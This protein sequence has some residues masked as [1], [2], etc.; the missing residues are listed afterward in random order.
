MRLWSVAIE[1]SVGDDGDG[2]TRRINNKMQILLSVWSGN[3][4]WFLIGD[5]RCF[6]QNAYARREDGIN[7][8]GLRRCS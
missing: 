7:G 3:C 6:T 5:V 2:N 4:S 1:T 8:L